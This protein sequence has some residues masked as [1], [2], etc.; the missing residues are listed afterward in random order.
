MPRHIP[1]NNIQEFRA[2]LHAAKHIIVVAGAGLSAA[3]GIPTFRG[4]GGMW[5]SLDAM[6]LATPE[7][8]AKDPSL[9]WQFYHYR[10]EKALRAEPNA[11]H[12]ALAKLS[13]P[14]VRA[15]IA[16]SSKTF[17]LITQNVDGLS[18][19]AARA[20]TTAQ[21]TPDASALLEMHG[22]LFDVRCTKCSH[23]TLDFSSPLCQALGDADRAHEDEVAAGKKETQISIPLEDLPK[24]SVCNSLTRPGVVW[25]GESIPL[26][27][28]LDKLVEQADL[29]LV[30][31]TSSLVQ[32]AASFAWQ[33]QENGGRVAVFN[34][35]DSLGT[36][37]ADFFFQGGCEIELPRAL[38]MDDTA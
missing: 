15:S 20:V 6:S 21:E 36:D 38:G 19:R 24:C 35:E 32:P 25:F 23:T 7:A 17:H 28:Q 34:V 9:V 11:A 26:L 14:S 2:I 29:C 16:P 22:R 10:R 13:I 12:V 8:F 5:R 18:T 31:G 30:V 33:V 1:S 3:S 37:T 4:A 27:P